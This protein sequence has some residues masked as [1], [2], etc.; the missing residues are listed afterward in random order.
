MVLQEWPRQH[1]L[2][3]AVPSN[4]ALVKVGLSQSQGHLYGKRRC[5]L[6]RSYAQRLE[7]KSCLGFPR[8]RRVFL[9]LLRL[10]AGCKSH[11]QRLCMRSDEPFGPKERVDKWFPIARLFER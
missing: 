7:R 2:G 3:S 4:K 8:D 10:R 1:A 6:R 11:F 5:K 9:R